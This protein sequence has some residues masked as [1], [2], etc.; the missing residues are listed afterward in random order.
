MRT[1]I[2]EEQ[3]DKYIFVDL[4]SNSRILVSWYNGEWES[5]VRFE[6]IELSKII[7]ILLMFVQN[8]WSFILKIIGEL[9][10]DG[11]VIE[12]GNISIYFFNILL[13]ISY[14]SYA[15]D[16][17]NNLTK[18]QQENLVS[19]PI[20]LLV[21]QTDNCQIRIRRKISLFHVQRP[22]RSSEQLL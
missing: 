4:L 19:I 20:S 16:Y 21:L 8:N 11:I 18:G 7:F 12:A 15:T 1:K 14:L 5:S 6:D 3:R 2:R 22:I 17:R 13:V 10:A 9:V